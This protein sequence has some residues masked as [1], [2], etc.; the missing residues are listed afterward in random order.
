MSWRKILAMSVA[1]L[2]GSSSMEARFGAPGPRIQT[3]IGLTEEK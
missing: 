2:A 3:G 1:I